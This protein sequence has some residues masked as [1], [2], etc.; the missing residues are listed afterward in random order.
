MGLSVEEIER[1]I[2]KIQ[3]IPHRLQVIENNGVWILDDAYNGN[4]IGAKRAIDALCRFEGRKCIV[5]PGIVECGILEESVNGTLG[6]QIAN[7]QLD[8]VILVGETLVTA[9]KNGYIEQGGDAVALKIVPTLQ[10]AQAV[11]ADWLQQGDAVLF[12]NDL[13][14][15]Y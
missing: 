2:G 10:A 7:A 4:P 12:L 11:L 14:D 9:I 15:V 5:T 3:P 13:P 6:G 1:G 8:F